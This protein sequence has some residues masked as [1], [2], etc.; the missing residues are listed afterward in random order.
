MR[1]FKNM[2]F[3]CGLFFFS[4]KV[5]NPFFCHPRRIA[6]KDAP[7]IKCISSVVNIEKLDGERIENVV[8]KELKMM[9]GKI[10]IG[11]GKKFKMVWGKIKKGVGKKCK[12]VWGKMVRG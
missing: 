9:W 6:T 11:V 10:K 5:E 4:K 12:M 2:I 1:I 3:L 8:G 7:Y